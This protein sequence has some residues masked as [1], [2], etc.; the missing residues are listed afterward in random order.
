MGKST[1]QCE[2][3]GCNNIA[4]W[5]ILRTLPNGEKRWLHV[6]RE[7]EGEIGDKNMRLQGYDPRSGKK[8]MERR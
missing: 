6:C 4:K 8:I 7:H 3:E 1:H 2:V 5:G